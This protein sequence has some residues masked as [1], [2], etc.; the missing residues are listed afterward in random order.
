M[1]TQNVK[2]HIVGFE[3][4]NVIGTST[5]YFTATYNQYLP[6]GFETNGGNYII[7]EK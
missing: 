7:N 4:Y 2:C 1:S 5:I 3:D 6:W